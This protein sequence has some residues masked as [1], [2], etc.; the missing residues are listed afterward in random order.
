MNA[1]ALHTVMNEARNCASAMLESG[2]FIG[3]ELPN[4]RMDEPV[5]VA[6]VE[7]CSQLLGTKHDIIH[8]LFELDE[9][10]A[11]G[12]RTLLAFTSFYAIFCLPGSIRDPETLDAAFERV[13]EVVDVAGLNLLSQ[14]QEPRC[15]EPGDEIGSLEDWIRV[16]FG[17]VADLNGRGVAAAFAAPC[18]V[19]E[20][21]VDGG[22]S[23]IVRA[24]LRASVICRASVS[25]DRRLRRG[26][27]GAA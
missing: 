20:L 18:V 12:S 9:L 17:L 14:L 7:I 23:A 13:T 22:C 1:T 16:P 6:T 5:R 21:T 24:S 11:N 2:T 27:T 25:N 15:Q 10:L 4:V 3:R 19:V 26:N 8:E